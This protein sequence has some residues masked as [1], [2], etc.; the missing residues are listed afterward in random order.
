MTDARRTWAR[1]VL[2]GVLGVTAAWWALA[3]WPL[4]A[5]S[6]D[7]LSRTRAVCFGTTASGLPD[8]Q[9]WMLLFL[10]PT[11]MLGQVLV[12]WGRDLAAD[13]SR[14]SRSRPGRLALAGLVIA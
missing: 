13:A 11:L 14:L 5:A 9:G 2:V 6:P 8:V 1:A 3:L 7:W 10:Q 12:I 4:P